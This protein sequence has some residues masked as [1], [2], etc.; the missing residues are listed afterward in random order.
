M[1]GLLLPTV[2]CSPPVLWA[3]FRFVGTT[4][5]AWT[6]NKALDWGKDW[7]KESGHFGVVKHEDGSYRTEANKETIVD[8]P[9]QNDRNLVSRLSPNALVAAEVRLGAERLR[10][11]SGGAAEQSF[12]IPNSVFEAIHVELMAVASGRR[13]ADTF[14]AADGAFHHWGAPIRENR[15]RQLRDGGMVTGQWWWNP[16]DGRICYVVSR[17]FFVEES[18]EQ[19]I[20]MAYRSE[21]L[22]YAAMSVVEEGK[23]IPSNLDLQLLATLLESPATASAAIGGLG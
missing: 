17:T 19:A 13:T 10:S 5:A 14:G 6:I 8:V 23:A 18:G 2:A 16:M 20:A 1:G 3:I 4:I 15:G 11:L 9:R 12:V 21:H 7:A 22:A